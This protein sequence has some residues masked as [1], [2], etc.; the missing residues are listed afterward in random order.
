MNTF[1]GSVTTATSN[2]VCSK[3]RWVVHTEIRGKCSPEL[4]W[5]KFYGVGVLRQIT[6]LDI[7]KTEPSRVPCT[8]KHLTCLHPWLT[9]ILIF[10]S[11]LVLSVKHCVIMIIISAK[12]R[13]GLNVHS[14]GDIYVT[15]SGIRRTFVYIF[16]Y[17]FNLWI[18]SSRGHR[19]NDYIKKHDLKI[20]D[21]GLLQCILSIFFCLP[22]ML[23][24]SSRN[25]FR[26]VIMCVHLQAWWCWW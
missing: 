2:L 17:N 18:C 10:S 5:S 9:L 7:N 11:L 3:Q 1:R 24:P 13:C 15:D 26:T 21:I 19:R 4:W 25:M 6:T 16:Q 23:C 22:S 12:A 20:R 14:G 8:N